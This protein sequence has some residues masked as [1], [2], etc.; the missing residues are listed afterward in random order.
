MQST[1]GEQR[2]VRCRHSRMQV[3]FFLFHTRNKLNSNLATQ[4]RDQ[5]DEDDGEDNLAQSAA[6]VNDA[7]EG[8]GVCRTTPW[9][10]YTPCSVT[11]GIGISMRTRTFVDPAG[12]KKCPHI[13]I[14]KQNAF[15][16]RRRG[17]YR[18]Q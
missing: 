2:D 5:G 12:R 16:S 11:C 14:G 9:T 6:N 1:I 4:R 13:T 15:Y 7:G 17:H 18:N 3:S 8:V 10:D